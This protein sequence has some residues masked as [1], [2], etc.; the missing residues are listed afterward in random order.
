MPQVRILSLR[1]KKKRGSYAPSFP[2]G[3]I[4]GPVFAPQTESCFACGE[5]STPTKTTERGLAP[6]FPLGPLP[7][8]VFAPQTESCFA[9]GECSTPTKNQSKMRFLPHFRL[10]F[11]IANFFKNLLTLP[12]TVMI[13]LT[14][15]EEIALFLIL[16]NQKK[17]RNYV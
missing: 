7:G 8:P 4:P 9:R 11:I 15:K 17:G 14:C 6:S 5:C 16:Q 1:P 2:L 13:N 10:I 3:P 12:P